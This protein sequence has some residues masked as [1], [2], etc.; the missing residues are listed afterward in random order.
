MKVES[1]PIDAHSVD[2]LVEFLT[3][4]EWPF[5]GRAWVDESWVRERA[6]EGFF[7][8]DD[9]QSFW[10]LLEGE[11]LGF[12]KV[13]DLS[14][15]T[16]LIDLRITA[17]WRG[18]GLGA[19][20]LRWLSTHVFST[21]DHVHRLGGYTRQDNTAMQ[22]VFEKCGF[23]KEAQHREAWPLEGGGLKDALGYAILRREWASE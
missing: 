4:E 12:A 19:T 23:L 2:L 11:R 14:D 5:H 7:Y 9:T 3:R 10:I 17:A 15:T 22:R 13:F 1:N 20:A 8:G 16:P 18:K 6:K 21:F